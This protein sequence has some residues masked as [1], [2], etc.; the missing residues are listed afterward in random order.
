MSRGIGPITFSACRLLV[1][2][3][4]I[5]CARPLYKSISRTSFDKDEELSLVSASENLSE[6]VDENLDEFVGVKKYSFNDVELPH[7]NKNI[8]ISKYPFLDSLIFWGFLIGI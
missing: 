7:I 5:I 6:D 2:T 4:I 3:V 1:S 8:Y